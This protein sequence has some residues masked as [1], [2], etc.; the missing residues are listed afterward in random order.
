[1]TRAEQKAR[2]EFLKEVQRTL[3]R[4]KREGRLAEEQ[5][6]REKQNAKWLKSRTA[7][8]AAELQRR[9]IAQQ[10][11]QVILQEFEAAT[12]SYLSASKRGLAG[13]TSS[14]N[15]RSKDLVG[16]ALGQDILQ[17]LDRI[18]LGSRSGRNGGLAAAL[19]GIARGGQPDRR[20]L[21]RAKLEVRR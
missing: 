21:Q 4:A 18:G 7:K 2:T 5:I 3:A 1:M 15:I 14:G 6:P 19:E 20:R 9:G 13:R 8:A 16:M 17:A 12:A 10:K 11:Q